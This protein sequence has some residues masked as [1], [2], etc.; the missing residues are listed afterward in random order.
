MPIHEEPTQQILDDDHIEEGPIVLASREKRFVN[1]LIDTVC[2][3]AT[4][5]LL[6]LLYGMIL[7]AVDSEDALYET[8]GMDWLLL[9]LAYVIIYWGMEASLGKTP[10][11]FITGTRVAEINSDQP[12]SATILGR[13]ACRL[14][15]FE[16]FSFLFSDRGWHDSITD[17]YVIDERMTRARRA[18]QAAGL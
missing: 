11:K 2:Y 5:F 9:I 8:A 17:T 4:V 15:P 1:Y 12:G 3:Y 7:G 13:M 16:P 6:A 10:A 18:N 14:I